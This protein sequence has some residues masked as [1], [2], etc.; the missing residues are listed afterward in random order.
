MV[1]FADMFPFYLK[2][3]ISIMLLIL[4]YLIIYNIYKCF[5]NII[6]P[7]TIEK[8]KLKKMMLD[9]YMEGGG[10]KAD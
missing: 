2:F 3:I 6:K 7:K 8:K 1:Y 10:Y 9:Y 5:M 4:S